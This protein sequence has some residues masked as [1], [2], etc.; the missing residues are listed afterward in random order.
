MPVPCLLWRKYASANYQELTKFNLCWPE[1]SGSSQQCERD[2]YRQTQPK[3]AH[4][5]RSVLPTS[6]AVFVDWF[7]MFCED[8]LAVYWACGRAVFLGY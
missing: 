7:S 1:G 5:C 8:V 2:F 6:T 3:H 4:A